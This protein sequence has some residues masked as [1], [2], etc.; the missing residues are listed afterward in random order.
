MS[1]ITSSLARNVELYELPFKR[2]KKLEEMRPK[3]H[4]EGN[5]IL[6]RKKSIEHKREDLMQ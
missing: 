4:I 1:L 6:N 2:L 3:N 5:A